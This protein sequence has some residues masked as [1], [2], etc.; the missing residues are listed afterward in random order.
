MATFSSVKQSLIVMLNIPFALTG[1]IFALWIRNLYL[2][3]PA[4]IGFIALFGVA[5]LNGIVLVS[6]INKKINSFDN[7]K[8]IIINACNE[9]LRPVLMTAMVAGFGFIP[10][11]L[12][13]G[14]GAEVQRPLATVVIRGHN[15]INNAY[16]NCVTCYISL[17]F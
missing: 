5:V 7:I 1:G 4:I 6:T 2:S 14:S 16:F 9:R 17:K 8:D 13:N 15:F 10:M 3:V 12:S 11:A